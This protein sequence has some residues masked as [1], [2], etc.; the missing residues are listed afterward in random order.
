MFQNDDSLVF[1]AGDYNAKHM[2]WGTRSINTYGKAI[3]EICLDR[4]LH[5]HA[6]DLPTH[7]PDNPNHKPDI[8]DF[9]IVKNCPYLV[10]SAVADKLDS[11]S[12]YI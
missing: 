11:C 6:L 3:Q 2:A 5:V 9:A 7:Y 12:V 10:Q 1:A 4:D 8:I